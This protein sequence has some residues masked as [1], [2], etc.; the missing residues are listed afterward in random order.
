[1]KVRPAKRFASS[2]HYISQSVGRERRQLR[3]CDSYIIIN[4]D[5]KVKT[6]DIKE[7]VRTFDELLISM[8]TGKRIKREIKSEYQS[9]DLSESEIKAECQD[10]PELEGDEDEIEVKREASPELDYVATGEKEDSPE[11]EEEEEIEEEYDY[12]PEMNFI[13]SDDEWPLLEEYEKDALMLKMLLEDAD[14]KEAENNKSAKKRLAFEDDNGATSSK[15]EDDEEVMWVK[16][17]PMK[18]R[19]RNRSSM[20]EEKLKNRALEKLKKKASERKNKR[21]SGDKENIIMDPIAVEGRNTV[22]DDDEAQSSMEFTPVKK[23]SQVLSDDESDSESEDDGDH[24]S[25]DEGGDYSASSLEDDENSEWDAMMEGLQRSSSKF[26]LSTDKY[27]EALTDTPKKGSRE[28]PNNRDD[29]MFERANQIYQPLIE[30]LRPMATR[31]GLTDTEI[32]D[33]FEVYATDESQQCDGVC[34]CGKQGLRYLNF[35]HN[36]KIRD[37]E[38]RA[39]NHSGI[40]GSECV[41]HFGKATGS[42]MTM[43][44]KYM[45]GKTMVF[46][47]KKDEFYYFTLLDD[48]EEIKRGM[49]QSKKKFILPMRPGW[50]TKK[51]QIRK[52]SEESDNDDDD[53][54]KFEWSRDVSLYNVHNVVHFPR[55]NRGRRNEVIRIRVLADKHTVL[56]GDGLVKDEKYFVKLKLNTEEE[57]AEEK[58]TVAK[59]IIK[60]CEKKKKVD[61]KPEGKSFLK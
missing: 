40:V 49:K 26:R 56:P 16:K 52:N 59:F 14:E 61:K 21:L 13:A 34:V 58:R 37:T 1:M 12:S 18:R 60:T 25:G 32:L 2:H 39:L 6:E 50:N 53:D 54:D 24:T 15:I 4:M 27:K 9:E 20:S 57:N 41:N 30:G 29:E 28:R 36:I 44:D 43:F 45:K 5:N 3:K 46:E 31:E 38:R 11:L 48:V 22:D 19:K 17:T 10:L 55:K 47:K 51:Y 7:E 42:L 23:K 35:V 8:E 33:E